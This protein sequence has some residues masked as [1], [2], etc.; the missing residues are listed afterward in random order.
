MVIGDKLKELR[1]TKKLSQGD[2]ERNRL[3]RISQLRPR[4]KTG[5]VPV[6]LEQHWK[7]HGCRAPSKAGHE[8]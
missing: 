3:S 2:I 7:E 4:I 5:A 8:T 6:A 1:D